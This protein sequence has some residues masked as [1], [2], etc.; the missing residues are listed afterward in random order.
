MAT[1]KPTP[2]EDWTDEELRLIVDDYFDMLAKE[3]AGAPYVKSEHRLALSR[4]LPARSPGSIEFKHR[5]ISAALEALGLDYIEGY[6]PARNYQQ[7][8]LP[9]LYERAQAAGGSLTRSLVAP[10]PEGYALPPAVDPRVVVTPPPGR[11]ADEDSGLRSESE[12]WSLRMADLVDWRERDA[13]MRELGQAGEEFVVKL[14]RTRLELAGRSDLAKRVRHVAKL[15]GD[16]MGYDIL[17]FEP[18]GREKFVEVKTTASGPTAPFFVT[19]N[20]VEF[21]KAHDAQFVLSRVY[22]FR[23]HAHTRVFELRGSI[24]DRC[25]LDPIAYIARAG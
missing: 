21:S 24:P 4:R 7:A 22:R 8:L 1:R 9:L 13:R 23:R 25:R 20:E 11:A 6:L 5:N 17:S 3:L 19:R 14:E 2:R 16:G 12:R 18:N 10:A 15:D